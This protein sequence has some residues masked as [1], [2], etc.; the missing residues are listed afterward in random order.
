M[1]S[2]I[3]DKEMELKSRQEVISFRKEEIPYTHFY[4]Y[5]A[6]SGEQFTTTELDELNLN[7]VY[8]EYRDRHKIPYTREIIRL[9]EKLG[10]PA[11]KMSLILGFGTNGYRNYEKGEVP[12]QAHANLLRLVLKNIAAL[13]D[14]VSQNDSLSAREKEQIL[15]RISLVETAE[16]AG[17]SE[18][19]Y[20]EKIFGERLPGRFSGYV[21]LDMEKLGEMMT[22]FAQTVSPT[23]TMMNKLLFYSDFA[24]FG[25]TGQSIS[26]ATYVAI[27]Y[28]PVPDRYLA[29][30]DFAIHSGFIKIQEEYYGNGYLAERFCPTH[31]EFNP[32]LFSEQ[33]LRVLKEVADK[34]QGM[35]AREITELSHEESAW[36]ENHQGKKLIDYRY[37]FELKNM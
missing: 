8:N 33:E 32:E 35:S 17:E 21:K 16:T 20:L 18:G 15:S 9:R 2:P 23:K 5:C 28:G 1:R 11:T 36:K 3:T 29:I 37:G 30:F 12:S 4:Y 7:Q 14:L 6:D 26:G 34:F 13:R 31:R 10:L 27:D 22:Y 19:S 25:R 24:Y